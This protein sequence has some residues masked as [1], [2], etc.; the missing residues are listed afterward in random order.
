[1][2]AAG[3]IRAGA[4]FV[5]L[6]AKDSMSGGLN[7]AEVSTS[8][9]ARGFGKGAKAGASFLKV[10]GGSG[11]ASAGL[12]RVMGP[13][14][15]MVGNLV[16]A[17]GQA[18][19]RAQAL[20]MV[21]MAGLSIGVLA[22]VAAVAALIGKFIEV[23]REWEDVIKKQDELNDKM[24]EQERKRRNKS[25]GP[26]AS[27]Q[28]EKLDELDANIKEQEKVVELAKKQAT[29]RGVDWP[30]GGIGLDTAESVRIKR[31]NLA[32]AQEKLS[33]MEYRRGLIQNAKTAEQ[34]ADT[35]DKTE[36]DHADHLKAMAELDKG[37][38]ENQIK[39]LEAAARADEAEAKN[40]L[41]G[42][43]LEN[44]LLGIKQKLELDI[45][46]ARKR[47]DFAAMRGMRAERTA[48]DA[49]LAGTDPQSLAEMRTNFNSYEEALDG[50]GERIRQSI[51]TPAQS[52]FRQLGE[53]Q[54][55]LTSGAIDYGTYA[56][57]ANKIMGG[58]D[59]TVT[60]TAGAMAA[61]RG[62]DQ[63]AP[64]NRTANATEET[65]AILGRI[66]RKGGL[67]FQ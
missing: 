45:M 1:M 21:K 52:A 24:D 31:A 65:A 51:E 4:A 25:L 56:K 66:E 27:A 67:T 41:T 9:L 14:A 34:I 23:N 13:S 39:G 18:E 30:G 48:M 28:Q 47:Y 33:S 57:A 49:K 29:F 26:K 55:A 10:L 64:V 6:Y 46:E 16:D 3:D 32:I 53:L 11:A 59:F 42:L 38:T 63:N 61:A 54:T 44:E 5:E 17:L 15:W 60:S 43:K 20:G 37:V 40:R 22:V 58:G 12:A 2:V 8:K 62:A 36:K 19:N 50:I 35:Q 7:T